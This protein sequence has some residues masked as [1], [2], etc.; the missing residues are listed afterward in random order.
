VDRRE[1]NEWRAKLD[2][3]EEEPARNDSRID[4][5]ESLWNTL[6][7]GVGNNLKSVPRAIRT[8]RR[9]ALRS[10]R[11]AERL[12][13]ALREVFE[14]TGLLPARLDFE[15]ELFWAISRTQRNASAQEIVW[16]WA[17]LNCGQVVQAPVK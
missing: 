10:Q 14:N 12:A 16:L 6:N 5:R 17:T 8:F 9:D 4:I 11:G 7:G 3:A 15:D 2:A 1:Y 13:E